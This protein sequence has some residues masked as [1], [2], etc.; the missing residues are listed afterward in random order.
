MLY[1]VKLACVKLLTENS[2]PSRGV[3]YR[4]VYDNPGII[5]DPGVKVHIAIKSIF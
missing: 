5:S 4:T 3:P 2:S 1:N